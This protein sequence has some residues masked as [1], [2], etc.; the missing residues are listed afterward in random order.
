MVASQE[1]LKRAIAL[2]IKILS[3]KPE[4]WPLKHGAIYS[5]MTVPCRG[6]RPQAGVDF[7]SIGLGY[8]YT[9]RHVPGSN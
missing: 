5:S 3:R 7:G 2:S 6:K 9:G 8:Q 1:R 4:W